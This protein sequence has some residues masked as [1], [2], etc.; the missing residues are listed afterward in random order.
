MMILSSTSEKSSLTYQHDGVTN[1]G[2]LYGRA[3]RRP[4]NCTTKQ[5]S[6]LNSVG[7]ETPKLMKFFDSDHFRR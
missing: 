4:V 1:I 2:R 7:P 5:S 3:K 6:E